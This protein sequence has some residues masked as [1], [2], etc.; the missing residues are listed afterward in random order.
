MGEGEGEEG[1]IPDS[2]NIP[3]FVDCNEDEEDD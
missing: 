2:S 1:E 3:M